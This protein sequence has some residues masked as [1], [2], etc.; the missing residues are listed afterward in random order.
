MECIKYKVHVYGKTI[1]ANYDNY[2]S[3]HANKR[4]TIGRYISL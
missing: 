3:Y 2:C 1:I 4:I